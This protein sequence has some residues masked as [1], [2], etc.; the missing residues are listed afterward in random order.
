MRFSARNI[1]RT[2]ATGFVLAALLLSSPA[3]AQGL[4]WDDDDDDD[5]ECSMTDHAIRSALT[6][7]GYSEIK[8]N[9]PSDSR[10]Q[11]RATKDGVAYVLQVN[12][13]NGRVYGRQPR[14]AA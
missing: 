11:A 7:Q 12:T 10:V 13:C 2:V 6:R 5:Y 4:T 8:L 14:G 3:A 9:V 1:S